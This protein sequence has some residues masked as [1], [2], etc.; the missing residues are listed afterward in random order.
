MPALYIRKVTSIELFPTFNSQAETSSFNSRADLYPDAKPI[1]SLFQQSNLAKLL[2]ATSFDGLETQRVVTDLLD[3]ELLQRKKV[4]CYLADSK[5]NRAKVFELWADKVELCQQLVTENIINT[6]IGHQIADCLVNQEQLNEFTALLNELNEFNLKQ[7]FKILSNAGLPKNTLTFAEDLSELALFGQQGQSFQNNSYESQVQHLQA[8]YVHQAHSGFL[9]VKITDLLLQPML[10]FK[11]KQVLT[12]ATAT[13]SLSTAVNAELIAD[14]APVDFKLI[15]IGERE[16]I[17]Q[18]AEMDNELSSLVA[19]FVE[20]DAELSVNQQTASDYLAYIY[21][22]IAEYDLYSL[23]ECGQQQLLRSSSRWC[24]H[25]NYLSLNEKRLLQLL[26][27]AQIIAKQRSSALIEA[28]D[29]EHVLHLQHQALNSHIK[30][31]SEGVLEKQVLL[32]THGSCI[33]Q[34][35]GLSVLELAGHPESF[36]EPVRITATG[37]LNGDGD[38]SDVERKAELAG[39][40]HAK[41]MMIIQGYF[42]HT[43]AKPL[44]LPLSVNLV[45]EQSYGEIDGDSAALAGSCALLSVLSQTPIN[46]NIAVTGAID[47]FGNVL[48]VGGINEK[49]EGFYRICE[50]QEQ[51]EARVI[52]PAANLINLN[53][54]PALVAAVTAGKLIIL[55]IEK[56]EDA[57][58]LLMDKPAGKLDDE[59]SIYGI[60]NKLAE[61]DEDD[62]QVNI[63]TKLKHLADNVMAKFGISN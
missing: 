41:A 55:P 8:G 54:S 59:E 43:F 15:L 51:Y 61:D 4:F 63:I 21:L 18:L 60:I 34:I 24:E 22:L 38:I 10:W 33:G 12:T 32:Q 31:S 49:I 29:I 13:W 17:C 56:I 47:Q 39:N 26:T 58:F 5:A 6:D 37:H 35:N 2:I 23:T 40:I 44:P 42:T 30:L 50:L 7:N 16:A 27:Y 53:L 36:G 1:F 48:A 46:Q 11:L 28:A 52:I 14:A 20:F 19:S 25:N 9:L 3:S 62:E 45:F 57:I